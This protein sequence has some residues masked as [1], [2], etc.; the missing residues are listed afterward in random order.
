MNKQ[1]EKWF[2]DSII[3]GIQRL[4]SL[5]LEGTPASKTITLTAS[6]WID[7]L[8]PTRRWD[9]ELDETRIAE[10]FR[11]LAARSER[12]PPPKALL[13]VLPSRP[14]PLKLVSP[15]CGKRAAMQAIKEA[16]EI[17]GL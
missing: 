15:A 10:A 5:S 2:R 13:L 14:E 7:V 12:W 1:P 6:T 11:Q 17:V 3:S 8:W 16:K 9:A 4:L